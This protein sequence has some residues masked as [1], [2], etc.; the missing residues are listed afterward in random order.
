[1]QEAA[2]RQHV[3]A[4]TAAFLIDRVNAAAN[5]SP[6]GFIHVI[7]PHGLLM[8]G[9]NLLLLVKRQHISQQQHVSLVRRRLLLQIEDEKVLAIAVLIKVAVRIVKGDGSA[10]LGQQGIVFG[11]GQGLSESRAVFNGEPGFPQGGPGRPPGF[12]PGTLVSFIYKN[13]IVA[14]KDFHRNPFSLTALFQHQLGDLCDSH[15][16]P[17]V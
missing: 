5:K 3:A 2:H 1:M 15:R 14:L 12:A 4:G 7:G 16:I 8:F 17:L 9:K 10:I 13:E 11:G 6:Q